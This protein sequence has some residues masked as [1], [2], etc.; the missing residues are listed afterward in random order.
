MSLIKELVSEIREEY[1]NLVTKL[2]GEIE[3]AKEKLEEGDEFD[4]D[5]F[6][7]YDTRLD[8]E[9]QPYAAGHSNDTYDSGY[10]MGLKDGALDILTRLVETIK[11]NV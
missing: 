8:S 7:F 3:E 6:S 10:E 5:N 2:N 4:E 11:D 1:N 9:G